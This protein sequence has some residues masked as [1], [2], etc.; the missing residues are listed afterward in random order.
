MADHH[1][2]YAPHPDPLAEDCPECGA[3]AGDPCGPLCTAAAAALDQHE[4]GVLYSHAS[5]LTYPDLV[6]GGYP[7]A[8]TALQLAHRVRSAQPGLDTA[9]MHRC[10]GQPWTELHTNQTAREV[11]ATRWRINID[12]GGW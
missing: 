5:E 9:L 11:L 2:Y 3:R 10:P 1:Q 4:F 7:D 6:D 8:R 12:S